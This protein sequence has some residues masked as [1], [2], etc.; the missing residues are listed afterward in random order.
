MSFPF[1][2]VRRGLWMAGDKVSPR[3]SS[4]RTI[5]HNYR[6]YTERKGE[7]PAWLFLRETGIDVMEVVIGG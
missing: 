3:C 6:K 1:V 4:H 2:F 5:L 7:E